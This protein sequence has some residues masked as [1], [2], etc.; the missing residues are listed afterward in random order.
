M[1]EEVGGW[2]VSEREG[3]GESLMYS[4]IHGH[5]FAD[6]GPCLNCDNLLCG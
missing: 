2:R 3:R 5:A 6:F 1:S 4:C